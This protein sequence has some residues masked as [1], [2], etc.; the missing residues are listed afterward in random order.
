MRHVGVIGFPRAMPAVSQAA[1]PFV[2]A[3]ASPRARGKRRGPRGVGPCGRV[4]GQRRLVGLAEQHLP[5]Q[6]PGV[7]PLGPPCLR[8]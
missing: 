3:V 8:G 1:V 2:I 5:A 7:P 4:V 6:A